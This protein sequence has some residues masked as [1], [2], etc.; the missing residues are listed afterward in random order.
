M[1]DIANYVYD[2]EEFIQGN[3]LYV[4]K[5]EYIQL[6]NG[7][8]FEIGSKGMYMSDFPDITGNVPDLLR[9]PLIMVKV[10]AHRKLLNMGRD[11]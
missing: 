7:N 3:F 5:T 6:F 2:F 9:Y 1:K 10:G 11:F 8:T 4:D